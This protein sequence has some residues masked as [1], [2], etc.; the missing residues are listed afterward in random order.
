MHLVFSLSRNSQSFEA[1]WFPSGLPLER[2]FGPGANEFLEILNFILAVDQLNIFMIV[3]GLPFFVV[4]EQSHVLVGRFERASIACFLVVLIAVPVKYFSFQLLFVDLGNKKFLVRVSIRQ[5]LE[6]MRVGFL[7]ERCWVWITK[8][9]S[10][11]RRE[12]L[13]NN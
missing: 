5:L 12:L 13:H 6:R 11:Q 8:E 1:R 9:A 2:D 10:F 3:Q 4:R 7:G